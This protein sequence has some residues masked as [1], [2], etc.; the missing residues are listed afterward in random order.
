MQPRQF[1][2][3]GELGESVFRWPLVDPWR[4]PLAITRAPKFSSM[5]IAT[6]VYG[7]AG[8]IALGTILLMLPVSSEPGQ[9]T[10]FIDALFTAPSAACVTGLVVVDTGTHY[11]FF[12][13]GVIM[14]MMQI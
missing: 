6:V 3:L 12:G 10:S 9:S 8:I 2:K 11:S 14:A 13:E 7:F 5:P 4:I 1:Q